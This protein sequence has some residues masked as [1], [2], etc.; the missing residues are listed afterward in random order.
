MNQN[1]LI[2]DDEQEIL[3]GLEELFKYEFE[4]VDCG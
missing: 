4:S 3:L 1:L 2:V